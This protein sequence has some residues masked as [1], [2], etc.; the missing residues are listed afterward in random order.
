MIN[1]G[2]KTLDQKRQINMHELQKLCCRQIGR[3]IGSQFSSLLRILNAGN[4]V[5]E[6]A[7]KVVAHIAE[8]ET[9]GET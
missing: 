5:Q 7:D 4:S 6:L 2:S 9:K 8:S 1:G 3:Q